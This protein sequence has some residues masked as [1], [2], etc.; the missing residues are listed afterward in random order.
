MIFAW[1]HVATT[2][3]TDNVTTINVA[4]NSLFCSSHKYH[5]SDKSQ[6]I[7]NHKISSIN[8]VQ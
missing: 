5:S 7:Q 1:S 2:S 3:S 4:H 8:R 6:N